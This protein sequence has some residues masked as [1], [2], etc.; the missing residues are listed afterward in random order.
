MTLCTTDDVYVRERPRWVAVLDDGTTVYGDDDRPG[1]EPPSAWL[2]L[3][4]HCR[5]RGARI[6]SLRIQFRSHVVDLPP[7]APGYFFARTVS[8]TMGGGSSIPIGGF[9]VGFVEDGVFRTTHFKTPE[10]TVIDEESRPVDPESEH[11]IMNEGVDV[12]G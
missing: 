3:R 1:V 5:E 6:Q 8:T 7:H 2:R 9:R 10:L 12:H 4:N 11:V